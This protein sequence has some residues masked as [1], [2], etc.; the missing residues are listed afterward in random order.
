MDSTPPSLDDLLTRLETTD[1]IPS[2]QP[3]LTGLE[4]SFAR[5]EAVGVSTVADLRVR[6]KND[7]SLKAVALDSGVDVDY[8]ILLKRALRGFFPKPRQ[9]RL[10]DWLDPALIAVL[11]DSGITN[12]TH[13]IDAMANN[14]LPAFEQLEE[15]N[16]DVIE[17]AALCDLSRVQWVSPTFAR[18]LVAAGYPSAESVAGADPDSLHQA[19][20]TVNKSAG[21]F[22]GSVGLRDITRL[23]NAAGYASW[24]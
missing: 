10:F 13:F 1:L 18:A 19:V 15:G 23:V 14:R 11:R 17:L 5:L 12:T 21:F 20:A 4:E 3:L 16:R 6:L 24:G 2:Q 9:L 22:K 7:K 8:L